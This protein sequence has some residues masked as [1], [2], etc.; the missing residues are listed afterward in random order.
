MWPFKF[1]MGRRRKRGLPHMV[2]YLLSS[3]PKNG[4]EL[5]DGVHSIT[6]GWWRPTPGSI[7]PLMKEMTDQGLVKKRDD[8]RFELTAKGRSEAGGFGHGPQRP[9]TVDDALDQVQNLVSYMEDL[10][11]SGREP[12][13]G[14][15]DKLKDLAKRLS[16]L[17]EG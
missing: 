13:G 11:R 7:Y 12:L 8:G 16:D 15:S 2:M 17:Q 5:M 6:R 1:A 4:V 10:K 3:S 9:Q 14:R